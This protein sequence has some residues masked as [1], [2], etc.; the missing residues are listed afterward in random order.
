MFLAYIRSYIGIEEGIGAAATAYEKIKENNY[1]DLDF[2]KYKLL[3]FIME[4]TGGMGSAAEEFSK[5]LKTPSQKLQ[6][7]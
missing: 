3:P 5:E 1:S 7:Q 4:A 2:T 6:V